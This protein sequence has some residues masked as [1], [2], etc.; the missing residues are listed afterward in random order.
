MILEATNPSIPKSAGRDRAQPL[1]AGAGGGDRPSTACRASTM[2]PPIRHGRQARVA[3]RHRARH[4]AQRLRPARRG[5]LPDRDARRRHRPAELPAPRLDP[6]SAGQGRARGDARP[7]PHGLLRPRRRGARRGRRPIAPISSSSHEAGEREIDLPLIDA[8]SGA[9]M[10][11]PVRLIDS[12]DIRAGRRPR[13]AGGLSGAARRRGGRRTAGAERGL[14][15]RSDGG[16]ALAGRGLRGRATGSRKRREAINPDQSVR[17]R[18]GRRTIDVPAGALFVPMDQPAAGIV[19]AALEPDSPGSYLGVGIIPMERR[20][21]RG[22][23]LSRDD[24]TAVLDAASGS[25]GA[26]PPGAL[27]IDRDARWRHDP[28]MRQPIIV[29]M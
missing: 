8:E 20:R 11:T 6:L 12:R 15:A 2:S 24:A 7:I 25:C 18:S 21:D 27:R 19:A 17:V 14:G 13:A 16:G 28:A 29:S 5:L 3:R 23:G 26:R 9:P 22:A 10:P 4:R 1:S